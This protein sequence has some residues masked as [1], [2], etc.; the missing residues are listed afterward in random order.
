V[1]ARD[2]RFLDPDTLTDRY[3]DVLHK[4]NTVELA[5][6]EW[7]TIRS[8]AEHSEWGVGAL[9][10]HEDHV[11]LIRE[12]RWE[13]GKMWVSPGGLLETG[14]T[15]AEGAIREIREETGI[16]VEIDGLAAI[17]E[18]TYVHEGEGRRFDFRFA[19]FDATPRTTELATDPGLENED[20]RAVEWHDS[21][22]KNT[23]EHD[24]LTRLRYRTEP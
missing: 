21:L 5:P 18:K 8:R 14:E 22:P 7:G 19:M 2:D 24:L 3:D 16:E 12:D 11:L 13:E 20:I 15:H 6:E 4:R 23:Y 10:T 17:R 1:T 9:V